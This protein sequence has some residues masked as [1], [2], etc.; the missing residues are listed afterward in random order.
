MTPNNENNDGLSLRAYFRVLVRWKWLILGLAVVCCG[1]ALGYSLTRTPL[2]RASA[3]L[4][5]EPQVN[6]ADLTAG[7]NVDSAQRAADLES[8]ATLLDSSAIREAAGAGIGSAGDTWYTVTAETQLAADNSG[9]YSSIVLITAVSPDAEVATKAANAYAAALVAWRQQRE[10]DRLQQAATVVQDTLDTYDTEAARATSEYLMLQQQYRNLQ[11][12]KQTATGNFSII[13]EATTPDAPFSP[14]VAR[15]GIVGLAGGI[16]LGLFLALLLE[17][18]DTRLRSEG[19]ILDL[20]PY[21]VLGRIPPS[22]KRTMASGGL[23]SMLSEPTGPVAESFRMLRSNLDF[24]NVDGGIR[25]VI[26]TSSAQREGKSL[27]ICNLAVSLA[28]SGKR[29]ALV[30]GDLRNPHVH[31][32]LGLANAV[33]LSSVLI[34]SASLNDA[35]VRMPLTPVVPAGTVQALGAPVADRRAGA[36]VKLSAA[37]ADAEGD[38]SVWARSTNEGVPPILVLTSGVIPPN[39]GEL[40][41]S[42]RMKTV[43]DKLAAVADIVLIDTPAMLMVG[44]TAALAAAADGLVYVIDADIARRQMLERAAVQLAHL[45]CRKLGVVLMSDPSSDHYYTYHSDT[46]TGDGRQK[47]RRGQ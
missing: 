11:I 17:Q 35:V 47:R 44:D 7:S 27:A 30:D 4:M 3:Q 24:V 25:T 2:Y 45:P 18:F 39:P 5:Y 40:I 42:S 16:V 43:V 37:E 10:R 9:N 38:E 31:K 1:L 41:A 29:V 46:V 22:A 14:R 23:V 13:I 20:L 12:L 32:Y 6:I 19:Q 34:R 21:P 36:V 15:T 28:L 33:G 8:V 26:V